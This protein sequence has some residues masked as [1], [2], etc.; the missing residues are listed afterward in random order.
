[1][2]AF[3][4]TRLFLPEAETDLARTVSP[5]GTVAVWKISLSS[6]AEPDNNEFHRIHVMRTGHRSPICSLAVSSAYAIAVSGDQAGRAMLWDT[7]RYFVRDRSRVNA[8]TQRLMSKELHRHCGIWTTT[9]P[10]R[11]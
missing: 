7:N 5:S 9:K 2:S 6:K 8:D 10:F 4:R 1:M 11:Q 3:V